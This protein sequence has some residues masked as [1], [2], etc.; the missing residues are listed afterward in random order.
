MG[1]LEVS[2]VVF[3]YE[4]LIGLFFIVG[5]FCEWCDLYVPIDMVGSV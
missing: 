3:N 4:F 2:S 1:L 5:Y